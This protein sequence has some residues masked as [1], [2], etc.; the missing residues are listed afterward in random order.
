[1]TKQE[2]I[3][4][5]EKHISDVNLLLQLISHL[6]VDRGKNHDS[7]K[8]KNPELEF[9]LKYTSLLA[10]VEYG[11]VGYQNCLDKLKPALDHHYKENRH[12]PEHFQNGIRGMNLL[13]LIEMLTDW[14]SSVKRVKDGDIFKSIEINQQ[15]FG[16]SDDLK[17]IL[18]NTVND[19]R[20]ICHEV[21]KNGYEVNQKQ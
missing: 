11:S 15:R 14:I 7:S 21:D 8:L 13:D 19:L 2:I 12:H 3:E 4:K 20:V 1:M 18:I 9:F 16:Y 6:L 5:T 10:G 17:Q